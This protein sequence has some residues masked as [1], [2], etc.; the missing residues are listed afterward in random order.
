MSDP[1]TPSNARTPCWK[2]IRLKLFH[3]YFLAR[4]PLT[5]GV[6]AIVTD[7][8]RRNVLLVRHTYV[9]GWH[10]PGGGV[11]PGETALAALE[12]ELAEEAGVRPVTAPVLRSVHQ[13]RNASRRDH[14]LLFHVERY[15]EMDG[16]R[17]PNREIAEAG[18]FPVSSLPERISPSSMRRIFEF[19]D[20]DSISPYW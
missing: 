17:L 1:A 2:R 20:G 13:N 10:L 19:F 4:R 3:C 14:V 12:R 11:E 5:L 18:F 16:H 15:R 9:D 8:E 6:R 7:P